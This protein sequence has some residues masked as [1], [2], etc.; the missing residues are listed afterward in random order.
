MLLKLYVLQDNLIL[1]EFV[2][3]LQLSSPR[4]ESRSHR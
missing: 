2:Y 1:H 4:F 3:G